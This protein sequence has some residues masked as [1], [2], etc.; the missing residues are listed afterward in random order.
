MVKSGH[1]SNL[2][3]EATHIISA[4]IAIPKLE[5]SISNPDTIEHNVKI[6][7]GTQKIHQNLTLTDSKGA[8]HIIKQSKVNPLIGELHEEVPIN[9]HIEKKYIDLVNGTEIDTK[10]NYSFFG[11]NPFKHHHRNESHHQNGSKNESMINSFS[12]QLKSY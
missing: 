9:E 3:P 10:G 11:V 5:V 4:N 12:L 7:Y 1:L 2:D 8:I 6:K